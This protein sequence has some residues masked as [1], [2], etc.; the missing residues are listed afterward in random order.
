MDDFNE[1]LESE[2]DGDKQFIHRPNSSSSSSSSDSEETFISD[3]A[4]EEDLD[5]Q[6]EGIGSLLGDT[7]YYKG[8]DQQGSL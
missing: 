4:T 3:R 2:A 7:E 5:S 6:L 8:I 1:D